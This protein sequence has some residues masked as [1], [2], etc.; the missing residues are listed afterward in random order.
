MTPAPS[1]SIPLDYNTEARGLRRFV[2]PVALLFFVATIVVAV[3]GPTWW[4]RYLYTSGVRRLQLQCLRYTPPASQVVYDTDAA[5]RGD[6]LGRAGYRAFNQ[7][8][9]FTTPADWHSLRGSYACPDG[10][11]FLH[12]RQAATGPERLV[13][14]DIIPTAADAAWLR[15]TVSDRA[16]W[17]DS[18]GVEQARK[19]TGATTIRLD[20]RGRSLRLYA[21]QPDPADA[22]AFTIRGTFGDDPFQIDGRLLPTGAV[23][24][25]PHS[26]LAGVK[27]VP[28]VSC[29]TSG[30]SGPG[31]DPSASPSACNSGKP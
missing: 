7:W 10:T 19:T 18:A 21:G 8:S 13:S 20:A 9:V 5:D 29:E 2:M 30:P 14:V 12:A 23:D 1:R 3:Y 17:F 11:A 4:G 31:F 16:G 22:A 26:L 15:W 6:L 28:G 27:D 24:L 25:R